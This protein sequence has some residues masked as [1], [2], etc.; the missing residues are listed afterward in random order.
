MTPMALFR[1]AASPSADSSERSTPAVTTLPDVGTCRPPRTASSVLL[2][3]PDSPVIAAYSPSTIEKDT[4]RSAA[5]NV[6]LLPYCMETLSSLIKGLI[7]F[8]LALE[9]SY[10]F[11]RRQGGR[12]PC[13]GDA[14]QE[15]EGHADDHADHR[16]GYG[17]LR[18]RH[19]EQGRGEPRRRRPDN[20]AGNRREKGDPPRLPEEEGNDGAPPEPDGA[21]APDGENDGR[22]GDAQPPELVN[23]R[24]PTF[25]NLPDGGDSRAGKGVPDLCH[26]VLDGAIL[27]QGGD[28]D[29]GHTAGAPRERLHVSDG[30]DHHRILLLPRREQDTGDAEFTATGENGPP[31]SLVQECGCLGA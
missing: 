7:F 8:S 25:H 28:L 19:A 16:R 17:S 27:A 22:D 5:A 30:G 26:D 21:Q 11:R 13:R 20:G 4:P 18:P 24:L 29:E 31:G 15:T 6:P 1:K 9:T 2:P 23:G 3:A 12:P 10:R 14:S